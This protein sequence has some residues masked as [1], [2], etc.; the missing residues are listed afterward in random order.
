MPRPKG[1][2]NKTTKSDNENKQTNL[3]IA[4]DS[5]IVNMLKIIANA[6]NITM[7]DL[8]TTIL[9]KFTDNHVNSIRIINRQR[10]KLK[11][12]YFNKSNNEDNT[13]NPPKSTNLDN[14]DNSDNQ[15]DYDN[16]DNI[17]NVDSDMPF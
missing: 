9:T 5:N 17:D 14:I 12:D 11:L 6:N 4:I 15:S 2:K 10:D 8:V 7:K 13:D 1:S 3:N 16:P